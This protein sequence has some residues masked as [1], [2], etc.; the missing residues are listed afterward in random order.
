M[1]NMVLGPHVKTDRSSIDSGSTARHSC[2]PGSS[3]DP[4]IASGDDQAAQI[5]SRLTSLSVC[6]FSACSYY[7]DLSAEG[8][9]VL[10]KY[11]FF[12]HRLP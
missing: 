12:K 7:P 6:P 4:N 5:A 3:K 10:S 11:P 8:S 1:K 2:F 9:A